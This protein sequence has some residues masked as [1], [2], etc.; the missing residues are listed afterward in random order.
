MSMSG[1]GSVSL[2][3]VLVRLEDSPKPTNQA[4]KEAIMER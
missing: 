1:E 2:A 4:S 3:K